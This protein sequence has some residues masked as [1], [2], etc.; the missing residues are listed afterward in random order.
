MTGWNWLYPQAI[1]D[2]H[3]VAVAD[4]NGDTVPDIVWM[5]DDTRQVTVHYFGGSD[6]ATMTG[7][8]WLN[9][10]GV[11]GWH[12]VCALDFNGDGTPIWSGIT[13]QPLS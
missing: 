8:N 10:N 13:T 6:R 4:F 5:K 11:P 12:V 1:S 9:P 3:V 7:W 2:W